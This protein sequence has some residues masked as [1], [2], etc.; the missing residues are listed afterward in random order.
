MRETWR[1]WYVYSIDCDDDLMG[2]Y[3]SP[4]LQTPQVVYIEYSQLFV[5]PPYLS[6]VFFV[7]FFLKGKEQ[8]HKVIS[9]DASNWQNPTLIYN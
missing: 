7:F 8:S 3:L 2:I 5:C 6:K 4:Y 9:I 1:W